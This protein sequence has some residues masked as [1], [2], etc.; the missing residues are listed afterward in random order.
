MPYS[1]F[2]PDKLAKKLKK[3][4]KRDFATYRQLE[5]KIKE[6]LP[7]PRIAD[8]MKSYMKGVWHVHIGPFVLEYV[9]NEEMHQVALISFEHYDNSF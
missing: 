9:I 7:N 1:L 6:L 8:P 2:I 3:L 4:R 5:K